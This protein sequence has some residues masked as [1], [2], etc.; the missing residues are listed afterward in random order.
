MI[1]LYFLA[2]LQLSDVQYNVLLSVKLLLSHALSQQIFC[3]HCARHIVEA[4]LTAACTKCTPTLTLKNLS[5]TYEWTDTLSCKFEKLTLW[6]STPAILVTTL[7]NIFTWRGFNRFETC[8]GVGA[9]P[10]I[11]T[12]YNPASGGSAAPRRATATLRNS[13]TLRLRR[14]PS[15]RRKQAP[16]LRPDVPSAAWQNAVHPHRTA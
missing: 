8:V 2:V 3:L 4:L 9:G 14:A 12:E 16:D 6:Q 1:F 7:F 13:E 5:S 10:W 11:I 15:S